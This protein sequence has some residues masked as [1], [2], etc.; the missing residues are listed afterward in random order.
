MPLRSTEALHEKIPQPYGAR[1]KAGSVNPSPHSSEAA[2]I[3]GD[4]VVGWCT[5]PFRRKVQRGLRL[6][7]MLHQS[8][9]GAPRR[10]DFVPFCVSNREA[11]SSLR[12]MNYIWRL[13]GAAA[14]SPKLAIAIATPAAAILA[15][16]N[17]VFAPSP[18]SRC[19]MSELRIS[20]GE[21]GDLKMEGRT[22]RAQGYR[23]EAE[24]YAELASSGQRDITNF[25][26]KRLAERFS[27]LAEDLERLGSERTRRHLLY[28]E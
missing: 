13:S 21:R 3:G 28:G 8:L 24:R 19:P 17:P 22:E 14:A 26:H 20:W 9:S 16:F 15:Q 25:V 6:R 5:Q 23:K 12:S 11:G 27:R 4:C 7:E 2:G 18:S 10:G 1:Q